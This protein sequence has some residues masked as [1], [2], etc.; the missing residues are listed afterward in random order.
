MDTNNHIILIGYMG[1]GKSTLG[2]NLAEMTGRTF[3]DLDLHIQQTEKKTIPQLFAEYGEMYF[4]EKEAELLKEITGSKIIATG[5]GVLTFSN[6]TEWMKKNGT[7]VYLHAPFSE[8]YERI[9]LDSN[10]PVVVNN[11]KAA[12]NEIYNKRHLA[13][14]A[15]ADLIV[16]VSN[17][18]IEQSADMIIKQ[19][20][21]TRLNEL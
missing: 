4:R 14:Q 20:G 6:T 8:L 11:T 5:G 3:I 12:L 10:R 1:A 18:S 13:Y 21:I 7:V 16:S 2:S 19:M 17:C 9:S 15:A